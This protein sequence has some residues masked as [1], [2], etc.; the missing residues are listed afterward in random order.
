MHTTS[1]KNITFWFSIVY[2]QAMRACTSDKTVER[3]FVDVEGIDHSIK[4]GDNLFR[5]VNGLWC[6]TAQ[7][8]ADQVGVGPYMF[9]NI[10]QKKL[11]QNILEELSDGSHADGSIE[12]K[13]GDLF[14]SGMDTIRINKLGYKPITPLLDKIDEIDNLSMLMQFVIDEMKLGENSVISMGIWPDQENSSVNIAHFSQSGIGL[15]D[16][17]YYFRTNSSTIEVQKAYRELLTTLLLLTGTEK[18][19]AFRK[20]QMIYEIEKRIC[21][22]T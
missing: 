3:K 15:P 7:I 17:D 10:P 1:I 2:V 8:A 16:R 9:L 11:L 22:V 18:E 6:D 14:A 21:K 12:Q 4:P 20:V 5:Y 19:D 13:L